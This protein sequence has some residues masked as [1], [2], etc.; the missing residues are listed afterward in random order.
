MPS[1]SRRSPRFLVLTALA[2]GLLC[3]AGCKTKPSGEPAPTPP[4]VAQADLKAFFD[5]MLITTNT[6]IRYEVIWPTAYGDTMQLDR[7]MESLE[8]GFQIKSPDELRKALDMPVE[9]MGRY[10]GYLVARLVGDYPTTLQVW[11]G[12]LRKDP[13]DL[14]AAVYTALYG[15]YLNGPHAALADIA[16][17]S[18][19][20]AKRKGGADNRY[21][22][23]FLEELRCTLLLA[24]KR[25]SETTD[26]RRSR[27]RWCCLPS[28]RRRRGW[29][30]PG[31]SQNRPPECE[32]TMRHFFSEWRSKRTVSMR[33][34]EPPGPSGR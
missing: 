24:D 30:R 23:G 2:A 12:F 25:P 32:T 6:P 14:Q 18:G 29:S 31:R 13:D 19:R 10:H 17:S 27:R 3:A 33:R 5:G 7:I 9:E 22:P 28:A 4:D 11:K 16:K 21:Q 1:G 15:F 26:H 20:T 8:K 34:P